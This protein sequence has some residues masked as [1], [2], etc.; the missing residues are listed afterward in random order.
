MSG[1]ETLAVV[2]WAVVVVV[3][4][5]SHGE[6][7]AGTTPVHSLPLLPASLPACLISSRSRLLWAQLCAPRTALV[8]KHT[9]LVA[10]TTE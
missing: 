9:L 10:D 1:A 3:D 4:R 2:V 7:L 5:F 6:Q 8:W